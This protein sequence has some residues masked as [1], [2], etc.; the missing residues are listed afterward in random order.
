MTIWVDS[1]RLPG[2]K[3]VQRLHPNVHL[4]IVTYSGDANGS[5]DLQTKVELYNRVGH[6]WP[7]VVYSEL[8]DDEVWAANSKYHFAEPL[9]TGLI[10][11]STLDKFAVG[12][13]TPCMTDGKLYCLRD[14]L[15]QS[16]LWYNKTL[17]TKF[18]YSVPTTWAQF[19]ALGKKVAAQHP[20]YVIGTIGSSNDEDS[21]FWASECPA[22]KVV[23]NMKVEIDLS[24][25][26]C[27]RVANL[28]DPLIKD[29]SVTTLSAESTDFTKKY[30]TTNKIL[31]MFGAS[32]YGK[33][34][35]QAA[36]HTPKGELAAAL[37]PTWPGD[38]YTGDQG[39]GIYLVSSHA[40]NEKLAA[41]VATW[42]VTTSQWEDES[43]TYPAYGPAAKSWLLGVDSDGYFAANPASVLTRTA[44]EVWPGWSPLLFSTDAVW[45]DTVVPGL[46]AG[47]SLLSLLSPWETALKDQAQTVGYTVVSSS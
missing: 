47:K 5:S 36:Y 13:Q 26:D 17:M 43:P 37:P 28:L 10:P 4:D 12:S 41:E 35:F 11:Q 21:Y 29:G 22:N 16:V 38:S 42:M 14:S 44:N 6:G 3:I 2:A 7:D 34:L 39:G 45:S 25:P 15:A 23:G 8:P 24:S 32:W 9:N 20:G 46:V 1:T 33:Y 40:S 18:G 30:G 19:E 27:T 31:M